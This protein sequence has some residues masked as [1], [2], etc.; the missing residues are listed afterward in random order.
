MFKEFQ[1]KN[2]AWLPRPQIAQRAP[3]QNP[4]PSDHQLPKRVVGRPRPSGR[5]PSKSRRATAARF[6]STS[7]T[8]FPGSFL[9]GGQIQ[10]QLSDHMA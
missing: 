3:V 9:G 6:L 5:S 10:A 7:L 8:I 1:I 4:A 2:C